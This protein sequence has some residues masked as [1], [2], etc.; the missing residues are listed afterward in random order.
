MTR[1]IPLR[2]LLW[3]DAATCAAMSAL[4][5]GAGGFLAPLLGLPLP[6]LTEAGIILLPFALLVG[7]TAR[8]G[9][10]AAA[11]RAIVAANLLWVAGS[12]V[13]LVGPWLEP[14]LLGTA[15]VAIQVAAVALI[16]LLQWTGLRHL[17]TA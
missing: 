15:F 11:V 7:W 2:P 14:T 16:S 4:L 8:N 9:A 5:L 1:S 13:L 10:P 3:F 6:L 17:R 12:M